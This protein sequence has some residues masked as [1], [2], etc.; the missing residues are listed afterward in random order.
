MKLRNIYIIALVFLTSC[1]ALEG[2]N[3]LIS[4]WERKFFTAAESR[5]LVSA[6]TSVFWITDFGLFRGSEGQSFERSAIHLP[7]RPDVVSVA[8]DSDLKNIYA[9]TRRGYVLR[10]QDRGA[11]FTLIGEFPQIEP[12]QIAIGETGRLYVATSA[13][14][15]LSESDLGTATDQREQRNYLPWEALVLALPIWKKA[16][17]L[18]DTE[19][20]LEWRVVLAGNASRIGLDHGPAGTAV[21]EVGGRMYISTDGENIWK[22]LDVPP[23]P[24]TFGPGGE[25]FVGEH[26]SEGPARPFREYQTPRADGGDRFEVSDVEIAGDVIWIF[27]DKTGKVY[28]RKNTEPDWK[29]VG[30]PLDFFGGHREPSAADMTIDAGGNVWVGT[31]F[32][33]IFKYKREAIQ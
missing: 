30:T 19:A 3:P 18:S 32:H 12:R 22:E 31:N 21:A 27:N 9:V 2:R 29:L 16:Q 15:F 17:I 20:Q 1:A 28:R 11:S 25:I 10:S 13:G 6:G 14:I 23:G 33:G 8:A 24:V 7:G 26:F 5:G 4:D